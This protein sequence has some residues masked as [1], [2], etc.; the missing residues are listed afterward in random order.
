M[1]AFRAGIQATV[2][3]LIPPAT[4]FLMLLRVAVPPGPPLWELGL[5]LALT[6]GFTL[7]CVW[8]GAKIFRVGIL[9]QGQTPSFR[10]LI[11]WVFGK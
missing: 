11:G 8:A 1:M 4:P 2:M 3:S 10:K 9:A 5:G 6:V 7:A